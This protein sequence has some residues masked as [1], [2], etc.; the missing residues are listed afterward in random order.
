MKFY[1][2]TTYELKDNDIIRAIE[3]A[4]DN[5]EDGDIVSTKHILQEV[6]SAIKKFE[7]D[8]DKGRIE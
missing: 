3:S 5:Y 4:A 8:F 2:E 1:D 7:K 6:L